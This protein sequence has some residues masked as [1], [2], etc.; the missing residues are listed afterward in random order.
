MGETAAGGARTATS[1]CAF[2]LD[3]QRA[4]G[5]WGESYLSCQNKASAVVYGR[6]MSEPSML[7]S[8]HHA[9]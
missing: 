6:D 9:W 3:K 5:G 1:A 7:P 4:D 8:L 2:L